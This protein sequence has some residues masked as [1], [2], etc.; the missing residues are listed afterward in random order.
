[1]IY[2]NSLFWTTECR[3]A[4]RSSIGP[5]ELTP[6]WTRTQTRVC[7][8]EEEGVGGRAGSAVKASQSCQTTSLKTRPQRHEELGSAERE[9]EEKTVRLRAIQRESCGNDLAN[10][11]K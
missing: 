2:L 9:R 7:W 3:L 5:P 10:P 4:P 11:R 6:A 8:E 1:M